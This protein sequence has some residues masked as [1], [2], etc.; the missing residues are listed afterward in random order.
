MIIAAMLASPSI[1][2]AAQNNLTLICPSD[3]TSEPQFKDANTDAILPITDPQ[4]KAV[5]VESCNPALSVVKS[6]P[7][8]IVN[9]RSAPIFVSFTTSDFKSGPITWGAGCTTS[10]TG[11]RIAAGA[12]CLATVSSNGMSSRFCAALN[13]PPA[14]CY[15]AQANHQTMIET[16]F[17]PVGAPGCFKTGNCVWFDISV[18][19][20]NCTD[21]LWKRNQC[22]RTGGASYNLPVTLGCSGVT[23][24]ACQGP[25]NNTYGPENYPSHCGNPFAACESTPSC[26]N[27]Y[28]YPMFDP[29][30]NKYQPNNYCKGG[31]V[32]TITFPSGQ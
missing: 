4:L 8:K 25:A 13:Q 18:I 20:S 12:T 29:P 21:A 9:L 31:Q 19:P 5:A 7:V 1:V 22:A 27:A 6:A 3:A 24:Y 11:A 15:N 32:F 23:Y 30:A 16:I 10:G 2:L 17:L 28:F 26:Q 14:N